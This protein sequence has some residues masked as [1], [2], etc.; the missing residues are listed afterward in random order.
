M[1]VPGRALTLQDLFA[2]LANNAGE[3]IPLDTSEV[4]NQ[5][6][7]D[8]ETLL[9]NVS[10][11]VPTLTTGTNY[12]V[13][14]S[15]DYPVTYWR[16][17]EAAATGTAFDSN[18]NLFSIYPRISSTS[19]TAITQGASSFYGSGVAASFT[20]TA[21]SAIVFPNN[22]SLQITGDLTIEFWVNFSTSFGVPG[23]SSSLVTKEGATQGSGE[24]SVYMFDNA[25]AG[26]ITFQQSGGMSSFN[27]GALSLGTWYHV[28]VTR[29]AATKTVT[30]YLNGVSA[31]SAT[32]VTGPSTTT[33]P[34]TLG[35]QVYVSPLMSLTEVAI[36]R[37]ALS[38]TQ[39]A[40]HHSWG[41]ASDVTATPYD[42]TG[43]YGRFPYPAYGVPTT[44]TYSGSSTTWGT[45][46]WK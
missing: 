42:G 11:S 7:S 33:N 38:A 29:V 13:Q 20:N 36:Y 43:A 2:Q 16:L 4:L 18:Q 24:Y 1:P 22:A 23:N 37:K 5:L 3:S 12:P 10:G 27:A 41:I 26:Q 8:N 6:L 15:G 30:I 40:T 25:G 46:A 44:E 14:V 39:V 35:K 9:L 45:F 32:Y 31:N 28:A 34:V 17:A 19:M 21:S